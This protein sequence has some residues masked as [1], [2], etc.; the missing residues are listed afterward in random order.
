MTKKL[1]GPALAR[2]EAGR[3]IWRAHGCCA[4]TSSR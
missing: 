4:S 1:T 3:D 2:F